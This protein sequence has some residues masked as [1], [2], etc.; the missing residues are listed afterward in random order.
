M[1]RLAVFHGGRSWWPVFF[2]GAALR[3][4]DIRVAFLHILAL[5]S[6]RALTEA[7]SRARDWYLNT[8]VAFA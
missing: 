1:W 8:R 2:W 3:T 5:R 6:A 4:R 7:S